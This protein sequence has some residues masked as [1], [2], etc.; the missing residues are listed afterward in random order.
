VAPHP[1]DTSAAQRSEPESG[2][3]SCVGGVLGHPLGRRSSATRGRILYWAREDSSPEP[4]D[5]SE[6]AVKGTS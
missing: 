1:T 6:L 3:R 4:I 5:D 2:L